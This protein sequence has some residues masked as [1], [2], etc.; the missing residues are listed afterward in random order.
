MAGVAP[1]ETPAAHLWQ[2][3]LHWVMLALAALVIPAFYLHAVSDDARLHRVAEYLDWIILAG[4]ALELV[5]MLSLCRDKWRYLVSNWLS[6]LII[7]AALLS[8]VGIESEMIA[9]VRLLRIAT[10]ALLVTRVLGSLTTITPEVT[11][12]LLVLGLALLALAGGGF[13]WLE[14]TVHSYADGLWLAFASGATVG[15]GD[16]VPTTPAS[17]IFAVVVVV[18]GV[19]ML[20]LVTASLTAYFIGKEE[21][22]LRHEM[23]QDIKGLREEVRLLREEIARVARPGTAHMQQNRKQEQE[24]QE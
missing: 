9:L 7:L 4:F 3:R 13:Y 2:K 20:S 8:V 23:H 11:P 17:K 18:V 1:H 22:R 24:K 21:T 12:F 14:P 5:W 19:A 15:Y 16:I 6:V 10:I